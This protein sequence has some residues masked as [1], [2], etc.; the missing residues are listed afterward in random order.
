MAILA[1]ALRFPWSFLIEA[2]IMA[3]FGR[4]KTPR[5]TDRRQR[6]L[7]LLRAYGSFKRDR[8]TNLDAH[9]N[10]HSHSCYRDIDWSGPSNTCLQSEKCQPRATGSAGIG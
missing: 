10:D 5:V 1:L 9:T 2:G 4:R 6:D 3:G 8:C 7:A